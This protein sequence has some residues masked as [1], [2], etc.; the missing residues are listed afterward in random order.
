MRGS[1]ET[2]KFIVDGK[3]HE[4]NILVATQNFAIFQER[5]FEAQSHVIAFQNAQ[6]VNIL[7][8]LLRVVSKK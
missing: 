4:K 8:V 7:R 6:N 3:L 2:D 5:N 1:H